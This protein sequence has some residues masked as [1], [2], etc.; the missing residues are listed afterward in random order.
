MSAYASA[1][2]A[3]TCAS[4]RSTAAIFTVAAPSHRRRR[5]ARSSSRWANLNCFAASLAV[6]PSPGSARFS[7]AWPS[8][9]RAAA[10]WLSALLRK[11]DPPARC[12]DCCVHVTEVKGHS[13]QLKVRLGELRIQ[14]YGVV[15]KA[16]CSVDRPA[17]NQRKGGRVAGGVGNRKVVVGGREVRANGDGSK[18][19][20][21]SASQVGGL[22]TGAV[23]LETLEA[24]DHMPET[25]PF[26]LRGRRPVQIPH[27]LVSELAS[28]PTGNGSGVLPRRQIALGFP[29]V[30]RVS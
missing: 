9:K 20:R 2:A 19:A 17:A 4:W 7:S 3:R 26:R 25:S 27:D 18:E 10:D 1:W 24:I 15:P 6:D 14:L 28:Q 11:R 13:C 12:V 21:L 5:P 8:Q 23:L 30:L 29:F 16:E 22:A